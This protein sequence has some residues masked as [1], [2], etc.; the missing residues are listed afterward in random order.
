MLVMT[1]KRPKGGGGGEVD[2]EAYIIRLMKTAKRKDRK[3]GCLGVSM[4]PFRAGN[5]QKELL[6][7]KRE[8]KYRPFLLYLLHTLR[9]RV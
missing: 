2:G 6:T 5:H 9:H 4:H 1:T 8:R 3:N 7:I